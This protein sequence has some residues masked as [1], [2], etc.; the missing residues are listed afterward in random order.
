MLLTAPR[1]TCTQDHH[2]SRINLTDD[3]ALRHP[4]TTPTTIKAKLNIYSSYSTTPA[5]GPT[6]PWVRGT[7]CSR[8]NC[9]HDLT[10]V[11]T[12]PFTPFVNTSSKAD[13]HTNTSS[14]KPYNSWGT[15]SSKEKC[16]SSDTSPRSFRRPDKKSSTLAWRSATLSKSRC[17]PLVPSPPL[18]KPWMRLS[19]VSSKPGLTAPS[20]RFYFARPFG[21]WVTTKQWST[22]GTTSTASCRWEGDPHHRLRLVRVLHLP[23]SPTSWHGSTIRPCATCITNRSFKMEE[24]ATVTVSEVAVFTP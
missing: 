3:S 17:W 10:T 24:T 23:T 14:T 7:Q 9:T 8:L 22:H 15:R 19:S 12:P 20:T 1:V 11:H 4:S 6:S 5:R 18:D 2:S 13:N 16:S 21:M